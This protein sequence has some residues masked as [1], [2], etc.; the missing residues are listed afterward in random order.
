M[1]YHLYKVHWKITSNGQIEA[2]LSFHESEEDFV[3]F[4]FQ[5]RERNP[6]YT[7][8]TEGISEVP[9]PNGNLRD[10]VHKAKAAGRL[11]VWKTDE[12]LALH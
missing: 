11:G 7:F 6:Q 10:E 8:K 2:K 12:E 4:L 3:K 1:S 5:E 9:H